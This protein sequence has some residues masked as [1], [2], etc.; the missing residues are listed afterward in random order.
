VYLSII[1]IGICIPI[2]IKV[3]APHLG[4]I[5]TSFVMTFFVLMAGCL[6]E[7]FNPWITKFMEYRK[8][9]STAMDSGTTPP[10]IEEYFSHGFKFNKMYALLQIFNFALAIGISSYLLYTGAVVYDNWISNAVINFG[11]AVG[12][13]R[14][15][16]ERIFK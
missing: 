8:A 6:Y 16:K 15:L 11:Y 3:L 13:S 12:Q 9:L 1:L 14:I 5:D 2:A 7:L 10:T 4:T